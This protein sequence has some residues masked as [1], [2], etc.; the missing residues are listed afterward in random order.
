M[1][2]KK[3]R[4]KFS[5]PNEVCE[6][7]GESFPAQKSTVHL[8]KTSIMLASSKVE[9]IIQKVIHE[10]MV[11]PLIVNV[12]LDKESIG[13]FHQSFSKLVEKYPFPFNWSSMNKGPIDQNS[14][15]SDWI[16]E[17]H[18]SSQAKFREQVEK[19]F[20]YQVAQ[21]EEQKVDWP[22]IY[23]LVMRAGF[24]LEDFNFNNSL[25]I[26][27]LELQG[28]NEEEN[29]AE[30][31]QF[32]ETKLPK[33]SN[34]FHIVGIKVSKASGLQPGQ[35]L[36]S[37]LLKESH[38]YNEALFNRGMI[39]D[40]KS[41]YF[42]LC[43]DNKKRKILDLHGKRIQNNG[44]YD[45][46][47][48]KQA[49]AETLDF[50]LQAY[51]TFQDEVTVLTGRGNHIGS[52]GQKGVLYAAFEKEWINDESIVSIIK[53][54][55]P[56]SGNGG[57]KIIFVKSKK[58]GLS[59]ARNEEALPHVKKAISQMIQKRQSRLF[60]Q[61]DPKADPK[62]RLFPGNQEYKLMTCLAQDLSLKEPA[63]FKSISPISFYSKPGELRFIFNHRNSRYP[64][65]MSW[66]N[67]FGNS[68]N[69]GTIGSQEK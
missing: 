67:C 51:E 50:I 32:L 45:G 46:R 61:M 6:E 4:G 29:M 12:L 49:R 27:L 14:N 63:F 15:S 13:E 28:E 68:I 10:K 7:S 60:L 21:Q 62:A 3:L 34:P 1:K 30:I 43:L 54:Y 18:L 39:H 59:T 41:D 53:K 17:L 11:Q 66:G 42:Y 33:D 5:S 37:F 20:T 44:N 22:L 16:I 48:A 38:I 69:E 19:E 35:L 58:L 40:H 56:L 55:H 24:S 36:H 26:R 47:T 57:Y 52:N 8:P 25:K 2:S 31:R 23:D 9:E 64:G 65:S